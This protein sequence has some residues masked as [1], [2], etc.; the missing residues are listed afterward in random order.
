M[1]TCRIEVRTRQ[2]PFQNSQRRCLCYEWTEPGHGDSLIPFHDILIVARGKKALKQALAGVKKSTP[3]VT[4][5]S[6]RD[7]LGS[8]KSARERGERPEKDD[9]LYEK[10]QRYAETAHHG[11]V[12]E[13]P[14]TTLLSAE[15]EQD[16]SSLLGRRKRRALDTHH[17][18]AQHQDDVDTM[19]PSR[20][21]VRVHGSPT[22]IQEGVVDTRLGHTG[23]LSLDNK[24]DSAMKENARVE[25]MNPRYDSTCHGTRLTPLFTQCVEPHGQHLAARKQPAIPLHPPLGFSNVGNTCY[26]NSTIQCMLN[27]Q[28]FVREV[29]RLA[30]NFPATASEKHSHQMSVTQALCD[31]IEQQH[32]SRIQE[33]NTTAYSCPSRNVGSLSGVKS[34]LERHFPSVFSG[35]NQQ[36]AHECFVRVLEALEIEHKDTTPY[37]CPFAFTLSVEMRCKSCKHKTLMEEKGNV[38]ICLDLPLVDTLQTDS[39]QHS[40]DDLLTRR[41]FKAEK[42]YKNCEGCGEKNVVHGMR[43][44]LTTIPRALVIHLK[45]F[46]F[47]TPASLK[48]TTSSRWLPTFS[49]NT[50]I[51]QVSDHLSGNALLLANQN[52]KLNMKLCGIVHHHGPRVESGHYVADI[53]LPNDPLDTKEISWFKCNDSLVTKAPAALAS[54]SCYMAIYQNAC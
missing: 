9:E 37:R 52:S 26:L 11:L 47:N 19:S 21:K 35:S 32:K 38:D 17:E 15:P 5:T 22:G 24:V 42:V 14:P 20:K 31:V 46:V 45:R 30:S 25:N 41:F 50:G 1:G 54:N 2:R 6:R 33:R 8:S 34:A 28:E 23:L 3:H 16:F 40:I 18:D 4:T 53:C 27:V 39:P 36:D 48:Q 43:R 13:T 10:S 12:Y 44:R 51:V 7:S 29:Q 49:K